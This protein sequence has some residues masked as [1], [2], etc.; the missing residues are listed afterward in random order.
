MFI[1]GKIKGRK[2]EGSFLWMLPPTTANAKLNA[3]KQIPHVTCC[4]SGKPCRGQVIGVGGV[5]A[6][7]EQLGELPCMRTVFVGWLIPRAPANPE[8]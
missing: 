3:N 8:V 2:R 5:A 4:S 1:A 6:K 7:V